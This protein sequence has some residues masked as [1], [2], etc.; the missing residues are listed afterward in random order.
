[1]VKSLLNKYIIQTQMRPH[2]VLIFLET[3]VLIKK[4][5]R[6]PPTMIALTMSLN[7]FSD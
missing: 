4:L 5:L 6:R 1:M 7:S 3:V 2:V